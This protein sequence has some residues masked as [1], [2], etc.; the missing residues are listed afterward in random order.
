[1][2]LETNPTYVPQ[3]QYVEE[4]GSGPVRHDG[5]HDS[6]K[7]GEPVDQVEQQIRNGFIRK[8]FGILGIQ[9]LVTF[10]IIALFSLNETVRSYVDVSPGVG[11]EGGHPWVIILASFVALAC[12]ITLSCCAGQARTY[13]NNYVLLGLFTLAESTLLGVVCTAYTFESVLVAVGVCVALC[14]GLTLFACQTRYDFT[15]KCACLETR[16][17]ADVL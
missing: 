12:I 5:Q 17:G 14:L 11:A 2:P 8:V 15:G 4:D 16:V 1:M 9:L 6:L 13:P 3:A 7:F 10:G